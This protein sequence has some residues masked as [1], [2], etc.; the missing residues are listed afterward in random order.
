MYLADLDTPAVVVDLDVMEDNIK[1]HQEYTDAHG[2]SARPHIKTHKVPA[3]AH[4]QV[5]AGA[6]G[7]TCQKVSEAE[8][9]VQAGLKDVLI[10]FNIVGALKLDRL[11]RLA[12]QAS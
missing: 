9:F 3:I 10:P 1:R 5:T 2:I 4:M 12:R 7:I 6:A 8:I 11:C